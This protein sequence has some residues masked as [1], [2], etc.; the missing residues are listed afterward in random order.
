MSNPDMPKAL[1]V[2]FFLENIL[3]MKKFF[4]HTNSIKKC[5]KIK[6]I[7]KY[8]VFQIERKKLVFFVIDFK[9]PCAPLSV[10]LN[11]TDF[12]FLMTHFK[13]IDNF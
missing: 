3:I 8:R 9:W 5:H 7:L 13:F 4:V 2:G 11:P 10:S 1:M 12:L 6:R